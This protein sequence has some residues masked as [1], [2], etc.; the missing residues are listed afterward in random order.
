MA[1][2]TDL[3]LGTGQQHPVIAGMGAVAADT[4]IPRSIIG[5]MAVDQIIVLL[6]RL[7]TGEADLGRHRLISLVAGVAAFLEGGMLHLAQQGLRVAAVGAVAGQAAFD[8]SAEGVNPLQRISGMA[9]MAE[10]FVVRL[11]QLKA[12]GAMGLMAGI[13][14]PLLERGMRE[15]VSLYLFLMA[16]KTGGCQISGQQ[17]VRFGGVGGVTTQAKP[18]LDRLVAELFLTVLFRVTTKAKFPC[19]RHQQPFE[20]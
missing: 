3:A 13:A 20:L 18:L 1:A 19:R 16:G 14:L 17:I 12:V 8:L 10:L 6:H 15:A 9:G 5:Q 11:Q 2:H 4:G 7:V